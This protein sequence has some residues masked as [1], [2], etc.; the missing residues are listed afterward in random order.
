MNQLELRDIHLPDTVSWWPPAIGWWV[1]L[2]LIVLLLFVSYLLVKKMRQVTVRQTAM[3]EFAIIKNTFLKTG[4]K[5]TLSQQISQLLRQVLLSSQQ[6]TVVASVTG[7]EWLKLLKASH[8][9]G[10]FK[11][12]WLELIAVSSYKKQADYDAGELLDHLESW[13]STYPKRYLL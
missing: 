13:L 8:P 12:E 3:T 10:I 2:L 6:R 4:N 11:L 5:T 9:K 7:E 1:L